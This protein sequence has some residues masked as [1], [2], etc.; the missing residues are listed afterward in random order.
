VVLW[1]SLHGLQGDGILSRKPEVELWFEFGSVYSYLAVM[2]IEKEAEKA[3]VDIAWKPFLLGPVFQAMGIKDNPMASQKQKREYTLRDVA[4]QCA[5]YGLKWVE[6]TVFPR[7]GLLPLRIALLGARE[8]WIGSYC[9][10]VM[11]LNYGT[12]EDINDPQRLSKLMDSIGLPAAQLLEKSRE[13]ETKT[14]L[15]Q[16]TEAAHAKGIFGAPTLIVGS[17]LFW[18]NDRLEDALEFAAGRSAN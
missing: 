6:P 12:S 10:A 7:L 15:R 17:E 3:G 4:R 5:K 18:G 11:E 8:P 9:R 14:R 16:Q 2:R 1:K 13:E